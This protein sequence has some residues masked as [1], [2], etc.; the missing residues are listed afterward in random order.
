MHF[1][2][3]LFAQL[4]VTHSGLTDLTCFAN[5]AWFY[6]WIH[7]LTEH[8]CGHQNIDVHSQGA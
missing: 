1:F 8:V 4:A 5:E 2:F 6:F 3:V 7:Y